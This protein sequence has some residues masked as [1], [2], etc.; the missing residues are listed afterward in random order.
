M[1]SRRSKS[2]VVMDPAIAGLGGLLRQFHLRVPN[3]QRNY[4]WGNDEV[5]EYL[6]DIA[7]AR[8]ASTKDYFLGTIVLA[9]RSDSALEVID[10][11]QRLATTYMLIAAVRNQLTIL[12]APNDADDL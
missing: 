1:A 6:D 10:S 2:T 12:G 3:Y 4:S 8:E 5:R 9:Q 11:H 7:S